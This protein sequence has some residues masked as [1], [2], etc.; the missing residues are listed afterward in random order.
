MGAGHVNDPRRVHPP[1]SATAKNAAWAVTI[2]PGNAGALPATM[3]P[4]WRGTPEAD[5]HA[6]AGRAQGL[7]GKPL[8]TGVIRPAADPCRRDR[9]RRTSPA[10]CQPSGASP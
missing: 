4:G 1:S 6:R 8:W 7:F 10:F 5:S 2:W 9:D 3:R